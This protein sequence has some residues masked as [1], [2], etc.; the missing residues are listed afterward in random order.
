MRHL[1]LLNTLTFVEPF[2][3]LV[4]LLVMFSRRQSSKFPFLAAL[5]GVRLVSLCILLPLIYSTTVHRSIKVLTGYWIYFSVYWTSYAIEALL[6]FGI[7]YGLYKLA[8][9]PLPG[10]QRLGTIMFRWAGGIGVV[11]AV[12][13]A[14]GPH[15]TGTKFVV[16]FVTE[17]QQTQSVLTLCMLFFVILASKPMGISHRSKIFGISLG[18]GLLAAT[19]LIA[20]GWLAHFAA[21]TS[22]YNVIN[23]LAICVTLGIW[24]TYFAMP[25]PKRRM[26][27]LPTTSPFLRWNQIS[28]VL[29]DEPGYVALG[30]MTPDMFAPAEVEIMLRAS[31]KLSA[32]RVMAIR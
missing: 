17:L 21:M 20:S 30:R 7:I 10:L 2:V 4:A 28:Q 8:M 11:L 29:G 31:A 16:K 24:L 19:D 5:L 14:V 1:L 9:E 27:V 25:E 3:C 13:L 18:L 6:G 32:N 15:T 22:V 26:I 23:G 12:S